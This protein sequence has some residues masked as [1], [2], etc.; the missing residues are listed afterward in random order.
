MKEGEK[1]MQRAKERG[2]GAEERKGA[3]SKKKREAVSDSMG[4]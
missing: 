4:G 3:D 2:R 1:D